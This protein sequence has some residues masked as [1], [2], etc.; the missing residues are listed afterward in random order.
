[1]GRGFDYFRLFRQEEDDYVFAII[2]HTSGLS[3]FYNDPV[4]VASAQ[5]FLSSIQK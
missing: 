5:S 2:P 3:R 1:M 4:N